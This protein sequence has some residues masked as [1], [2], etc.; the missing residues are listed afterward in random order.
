MEVSAPEPAPGDEG[1]VETAVLGTR[2]TRGQRG[3]LGSSGTPALDPQHTVGKE[4]DR[5]SFLGK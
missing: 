2:R 1:D 5:L 4:R 3:P